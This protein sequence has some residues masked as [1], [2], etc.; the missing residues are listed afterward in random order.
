MRIGIEKKKENEEYGRKE[1]SEKRELVARVF[2]AK[3]LNR[4]ERSSEGE[5]DAVR[6]FKWTGHSVEVEMKWD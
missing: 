1:W 5:N 2:P 4:W 6:K 3:T